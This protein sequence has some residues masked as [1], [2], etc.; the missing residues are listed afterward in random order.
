MLLGRLSLMESRKVRVP[1]QVKKD[2]QNEKDA[3]H[4][5]VVL[6]INGEVAG[7]LSYQDE[8]RPHMKDIIAETKAV[9]GVKEWHMLT[10]D[11]ERAASAVAAELG[12]NHFHANMTPE[13]KMAF[14]AKFERAKEPEVVGYIGDGV[15]D[16]ASLALAD[17]GIAM[18]GIGSDAAIEAADITIMHDHLGRLPEVMKTARTVRNIMWQCFGIWI[19]TNAFGLTW[20]T[21]GIPGLGILGPAG[22]AAFN[23][24]TDFIPIGN[25]L[26]AG[27]RWGK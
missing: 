24:L 6:S 23:F 14:V 1:E 9:G 27:R 12:I 18:G 15:N 21:V 2:I 11:N 20:V 22:A 16:A 19:V 26:R 25:A 10:G 3:G 7:L 13:S 17:V 8:L 4:G 5:V